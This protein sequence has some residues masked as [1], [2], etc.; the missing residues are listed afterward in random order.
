MVFRRRSQYLRPVN[1]LKHVIDIQGGLIA[2]TQAVHDIVLGE[3][4]PVT[5]SNPDQVNIGSHVRSI[6]LN[7]QVAATGAG[8]L[9]NVYMIIFGNPGGQI[10]DG[11]FPEGN[12]VGNSDLRKFVFHQEM[13]MTEKSTTA[14]PRTLFRGVLKIPRKYNRIGANDKISI[15]IFSPGVTYDF[16]FQCIY[17]EI[18]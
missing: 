16:C 9:A 14:F 12:V 1:T 7:L 11:T 15:G 10:A 17:K 3:D 6:F 13:I 2:G 5:G 4:N 8:A 18:R